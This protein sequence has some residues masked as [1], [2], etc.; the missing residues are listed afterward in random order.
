MKKPLLILL[1]ILIFSAHYTIAQHGRLYTDKLVVGIYRAEHMKETIN[2]RAVHRFLTGLSYHISFTRSFEIF[3]G[4]GFNFIPITDYCKVCSDAFYGVGH[5][6]EFETQAGIGF[7]V[8]RHA[9][10]PVYPFSIIYLFYSATKYKG[11]FDGGILGQG[12][13]FSNQ[14]SK[15]G[16]FI[17]AGIAWDLPER[18]Y[19]SAS[20]GIGGGIFNQKGTTLAS[21]N[22]LSFIP[23]EVRLGVYFGK[24]HF[25]KK[26]CTNI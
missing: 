26:G 1:L 5:Y 25:R 16:S 18:G 24:S 10:S 11:E 17:K 14:Y 8:N 21:G 23:F 2:Q 6:N 7:N 9:R 12:Y 3:A 13:D 19:V 20:T 4:V 22:Y 15:I